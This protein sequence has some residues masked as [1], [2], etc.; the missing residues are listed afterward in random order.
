VAIRDERTPAGASTSV[1][2]SFFFREADL[3][4]GFDSIRTPEEK[5]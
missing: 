1:G 3:D 4:S 2:V 5:R